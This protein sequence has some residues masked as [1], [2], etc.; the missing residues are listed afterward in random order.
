MEVQI[1]SDENA[2]NRKKL[3]K[4]IDK[5]N[6]L[7]SKNIEGQEKMVIAISS[8]LFG[9]LLAIFDK[10]LIKAKFQAVCFVL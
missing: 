5:C 4:T 10:D 9:L 2:E 1:R 8:A 7:R 3:E 6:D